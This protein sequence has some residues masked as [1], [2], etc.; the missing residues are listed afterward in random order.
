[1]L[2]QP[3]W[4]DAAAF[5][6]TKCLGVIWLAFT[7]FFKQKCFGLFFPPSGEKSKHVP[8]MTSS[9]LLSQYCE[10]TVHVCGKMTSK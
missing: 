7:F 3:C 10:V 1:M 9:I 8:I 5:V 2:K 6:L 4:Q